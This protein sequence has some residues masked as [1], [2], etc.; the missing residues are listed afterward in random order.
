MRRR[1]LAKAIKYSMS[2][3]SNDYGISNRDYVVRVEHVSGAY[4]FSYMLNKRGRT[5]LL[6]HSKSGAAA[7]VPAVVVEFLKPNRSIYQQLVH[8]P[9]YYHPLSCVKPVQADSNTDDGGT[10]LIGAQPYYTMD[11]SLPS[12][13]ADNNLL[14]ANLVFPR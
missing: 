13:D 2:V 9:R 10:I 1:L 5:K 11:F 4:S 6:K 14:D 7:N 8:G 12:G 3:A